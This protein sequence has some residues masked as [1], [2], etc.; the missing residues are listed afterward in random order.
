MC[1]QTIKIEIGQKIR[2]WTVIEFDPSKGKGRYYFCQCKCGKILSKPVDEL[3]RVGPTQ[4]KSCACK[5]RGFNK[6]G[7]QPLKLE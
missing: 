3:I 2:E 1:P 5:F 7:T 6:L 4:C